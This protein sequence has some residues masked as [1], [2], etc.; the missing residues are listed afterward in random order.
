LFRVPE[1]VTADEAAD[2]LGVGT[3]HIHVWA[4][5]GLL[6]VCARGEDGQLL[7]RR[8]RIEK[9]GPKLVSA[10]DIEPRFK[11]AGGRRG[12]A[13]FHDCRKLPCGCAIAG[14][15]GDEIGK[16]A[17]QPV[18]LCAD[19]RALQSAERLATAFAM[20][21]PGDPF[22]RRLAAVTREAFQRHVGTVAPECKPSAHLREG[23]HC[24][25]AIAATDYGQLV[26]RFE[27]EAPAA[28]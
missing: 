23:G 19:A 7:F 20:A 25:P 14:S 26:P 22:F 5:D 3:H 28:P 4:G 18:W 11:K 13:M 17:G 21:A 9:L 8:W 16:D 10:A 12:H 6:P 27:P 2:L 15:E 24:G 1:I